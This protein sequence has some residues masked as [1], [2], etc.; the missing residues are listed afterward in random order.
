MSPSVRRSFVPGWE[1][2]QLSL[3]LPP[4]RVIRPYNLT[5]PSA[6][7]RRGLPEALASV[8]VPVSMALW[9][10]FILGV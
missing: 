7:L 8:L 3:T 6:N 1:R 9:S 2:V 4:A 5:T 10:L